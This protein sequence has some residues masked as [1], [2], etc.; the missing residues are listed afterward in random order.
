MAGAAGNHGIR[1]VFAHHLH[2][3]LDIMLRHG[4]GRVEPDDFNRPVFAGDFLDL[5]Q[6]LFLEV[7]VKGRR[8]ALLVFI[9]E[10][11]A[12]GCVPVL[13][14]GVVATGFDP[15][16]VVGV[17]KTE[18]NAD[19]AARF[20][21]LLH[22]VAAKRRGI[23]DVEVMRFRVIHR[24]AVVMLAGD[25]DVLH[26]RVL[27]ELGDRSGIELHRIEI[28]GDFFVFRHR[29]VRH[30]VVH[31]PFADAVIGFPVDLVCQLRVKTPVNKH[32]VIGFIEALFALGKAR[33]VF[34]FRITPHFFHLLGFQG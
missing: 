30:L 16:L 22:R 10:T 34:N 13:I 17:I 18:S 33:A 29:D 11:I 14:M 7:V 25:D 26:A 2:Q 20:G 31:D 19:L 9:W 6:A 5:G 32:C 21:K 3:L 12:S 23:H 27:G 1:L 28:L 24:K 4:A 8:H 15:V